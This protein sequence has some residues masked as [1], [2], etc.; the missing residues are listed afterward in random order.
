MELRGAQRRV[1]HAGVGHDPFGGELGAEVAEH[2]TVDCA[3][4]RDAVRA[5]DRDVHE[6]ARAGRRRGSHEIAGLVFVALGTAGAVHDRLDAIDRGRNA[7]AGG[8]ITGDVF[9]AVG[10]VRAVPAEHPYGAA[11]VAQARNHQSAESAGPTGDQDGRRHDAYPC[12]VFCMV[13]L[14]Q[15]RISVA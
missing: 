3:D 15:N 14:L 8:Q 7:V 6:M 2:R 9:D 11:G 10:G 12:F 4:D 13:A 5:D 1:R